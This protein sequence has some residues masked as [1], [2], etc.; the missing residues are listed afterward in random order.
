MGVRSKRGV[1]PHPRAVRLLPVLLLRLSIG[2]DSEAAEEV[3]AFAEAG[4]AVTFGWPLE[5]D[6]AVSIFAFA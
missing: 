4:G 1:L 3:P 2:C 5:L 6:E